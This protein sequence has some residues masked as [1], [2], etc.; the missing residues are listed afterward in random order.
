MRQTPL[1]NTFQTVDYGLATLETFDLT[2]NGYGGQ[3]IKGWLLL[4]RHR[5]GPLPCV[6]EFIGYRGGRGF[7][8]DW[9]LW[10]SCGYAQLIIDTR[11]QG[12]AW[13]KGGTPDLETDGASPYFPGFL[14]RGILQPQTYYYRRVFT[15]AVRAVEVALEHPAIDKVLS[16]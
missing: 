16:R 4:P 15:D 13:I 12:S 7:P 3:P 9:L 14:T 2:F 10:V 1:N 8:G 11:G 6:V 5:S